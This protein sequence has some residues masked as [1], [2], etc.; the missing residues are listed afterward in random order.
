MTSKTILNTTHKQ[1]SKIINSEKVSLCNALKELLV[2]FCIGFTLLILFSCIFGLIFADE[3]AKPGIIMCLS[4]G[5]AMLICA[6]L[7]LVFF[8]PVFIKRMSYVWRLS[9]FG[10]CLYAILAL[11]GAAFSWFPTDN[12]G[13]WIA[14]TA[15]YLI[16]LAFMSIIFTLI[17]KRTIKTLNKRLAEFKAEHSEQEIN[18]S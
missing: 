17:N 1:A 12:F 18:G 10:I 13:A 5:V 8:T 15:T 14:F 11:C 16:I 6:V 3:A 4:I 7:Q 2:N 9:F